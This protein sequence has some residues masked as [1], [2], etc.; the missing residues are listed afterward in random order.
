MAI[1]Y[2]APTANWSTATRTTAEPRITHPIQQTLSAVFYDVDY[3][4]G[5]TYFRKLALDTFMATTTLDG[6]INSSTTTIT[7][8]STDGFPPYGGIKIGAE[9]ID[10]TGRTATTFT[11]CVVVGS[12]SDGATVDTLAFLVNESTPAATGGVVRWTRRYATTPDLWWEYAQSVFTF[13]GYYN[14]PYESAYRCPQALNVSFLTT[15]VYKQTTDPMADLDVAAQMFRVVDADSCV[16]DYVDTTTTPTYA[17]YIAAVAAEDWMY[18]SQS[19]L[20][21]YAGNIWVRQQHWCHPL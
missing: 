1:T 3:V 5:E 7:V 15:L 9:E 20:T 8:D 18:A 13:P 19:T 10:Y 2:D 6:S 11:G 21:R 17:T 16:L 12:H 4:Q 14:D